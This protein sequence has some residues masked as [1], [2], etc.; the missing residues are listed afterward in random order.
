MILPI[1]VDES[2]ALDYPPSVVGRGRLECA[3]DNGRRARREGRGP[4]DGLS[5]NNIA[6][7]MRYAWMLG[8]IREHEAIRDRAHRARSRKMP[9]RCE[10]V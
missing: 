3:F 8:W 9:S 2:G 1:D 7:G 5:R 10:D 4:G 6:L